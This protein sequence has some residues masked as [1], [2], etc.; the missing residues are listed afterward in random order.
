MKK[1]LLLL[2]L[3]LS[4]TIP[5]S[6]WE[7]ASFSEAL[8]DDPRWRSGEVPLTVIE[9][10]GVKAVD[11]LD[12]S[13]DAAAGLSLPLSREIADEALAAGFTLDMRFKLVVEGSNFSMLARLSENIAVFITPYL[14]PKSQDLSIRVWDRVEE[15]EVTA[16]VGPSD[17]FVDLKAIY[18]PGVGGEPGTMVIN[19]NGD[20][21]IELRTAS[22]EGAG[23]S[24]PSLDIGAR[25]LD[26]TGQTLVQSLRFS[27]P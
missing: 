21:L 18:R 11:F 6:A 2:T 23:G 15:K 16:L 17:R 10:D 8:P 26:R 3:T 14:D 7:V 1:I 12:E 4:S 24:H 20:P 22:D 13:Q 25:N 9:D 19:I 27:I 5:C